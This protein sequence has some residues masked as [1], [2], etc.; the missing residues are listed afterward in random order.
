M[1]FKTCKKC[2]EKKPLDRKHFY[3]NKSKEDGWHDWCKVC[4]NISSG[5]VPL[6][7]AVEIIKPIEQTTRDNKI[8]LDFTK[9]PDV[10][11]KV[12]Q[13]AD[14]NMRD[15][16]KQILYTLKSGTLNF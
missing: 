12:R 3:R 6:A 2:G 8:I 10:L 16:D 1:E 11:E 5:K 13:W 15:V 9:Y 14:D 4:H 7:E